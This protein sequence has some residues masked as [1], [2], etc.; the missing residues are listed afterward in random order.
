[1]VEGGGKTEVSWASGEVAVF[2]ASLGSGVDDGAN[3]GA[4]AG[5]TDIAYSG[6]GVGDV[7]GA[8]AGYAG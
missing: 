3:V 8:I 2:L 5:V 6:T 4:G 1:M 7:N